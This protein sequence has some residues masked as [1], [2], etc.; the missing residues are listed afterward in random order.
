MTPSLPEVG[1]FES[2]PAQ[3]R[4]VRPNG[5]ATL[6]LSYRERGGTADGAARTVLKLKTR[7]ADGKS[8]WAHRYRVDGRG[9][10][11]ATGGRVRESARGSAGVAGRARAAASPQRAPRAITLS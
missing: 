9:S 4:R 1:P 10:G 5:S 8:T 6:A 3:L 2:A 11:T 7:G